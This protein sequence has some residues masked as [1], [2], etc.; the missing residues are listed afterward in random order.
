MYNT[1]RGPSARLLAQAVQV[2]HWPGLPRA[3]HAEEVWTPPVCALSSPCKHLGKANFWRQL[4]KNGQERSMQH[5]G[6]KAR[7]ECHLPLL[8]CPSF[9]CL[10]LY[11]GVWEQADI[12][13]HD[14]ERKGLMD[15]Q[16]QANTM[17]SAGLD[18]VISLG[19]RGVT[20]GWGDRLSHSCPLSFFPGMAPNPKAQLCRPKPWLGSEQVPGKQTGPSP[21]LLEEKTTHN[22]AKTFLR[23]S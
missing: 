21:H 22:Q 11:M 5:V 10:L 1:V 15:G 4:W 19:K 17:I 20:G 14:I 8:L 12:G 9:W 7:L 23:K 6:K 3:K 2:N 16:R 18:V 13:V